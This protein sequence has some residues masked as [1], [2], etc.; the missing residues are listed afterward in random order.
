MKIDSWSPKQYDK[1]KDERSA[2]FFDLMSLVQKAPG[3]RVVDLGCGSGEL[4]L[5]LHRYTEASQ[6]LGIDTSD[7]MLLMAEEFSQDGLQFH[8]ENIQFWHSKNEFDI[9]FSNAAL[10]WCPN[11]PAIFHKLKE[12]LKEGG[13][14]AVQMPMN[15][16][17]PTH[18]LA[19]EMSHEEPWSSLLGVEKYEKNK[20]MLRLEQYSQLITDLGF[21]KKRVFLK[22]YEHELGSRDD[23]I[24]W[25]KGSL[26]THFKSRLK[27][28]D[29]EHF[30]SEFKKRLFTSLPDQRPFFYPF[31]RIFIWASK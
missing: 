21:K 23:V 1:F 11:H 9:V 18:I 14:L 24:E 22:T 10:Q 28:K 6:T 25:V 29:N 20:T 2:P 31:K 12:A 15:H 4:S 3:S 13:Q 8:K 5:E 7:E 27:E 17:Y 16:D 26:L 30:V 19:H